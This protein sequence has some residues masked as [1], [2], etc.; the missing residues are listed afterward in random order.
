[1]TSPLETTILSEDNSADDKGW[2]GV[3]THSDPLQTVIGSDKDERAILREH[4]TIRM[5][6]CEFSICQLCERSAICDELGKIVVQQ[7]EV[8][9]LTTYESILST[10]VAVVRL[11]QSV[12]TDDILGYES[13]SQVPSIRSCGERS[14]LIG[15]GNARSIEQG[16]VDQ[17]ATRERAGACE[18][19]STSVTTCCV[20]C[21]SAWRCGSV[22]C[23]KR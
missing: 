3:V 15:C 19:R 1:M 10:Y 18:R 14:T 2:C 11:V 13:N 9:P 16:K 12:K 4:K 17:A 5:R 8:D 21:Q 7:G 22:A 23:L 6:Q 20:A